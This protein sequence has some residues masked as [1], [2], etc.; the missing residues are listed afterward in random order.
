MISVAPIFPGLISD[1]TH[2]LV[3][4]GVGLGEL[5]RGKLKK[6]KKDSL[7]QRSASFFYERPEHKYFRLCGPT[8][9]TEAVVQVLTQ[10][11]KMQAFQH[12]KTL[13]S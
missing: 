5:F 13:F 4:T 11:V 8:G 10:P 7:C 3:W 6:K 1:V 9:K 12:V 2:S